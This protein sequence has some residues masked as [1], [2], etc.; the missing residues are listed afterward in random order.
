MRRV[1]SEAHTPALHLET[2]RPPQGAVTLNVVCSYWL[3]RAHYDAVILVKYTGQT[4]SLCHNFCERPP[5]QPNCGIGVTG[6]KETLQQQ[7]WWWWD[8][9]RKSLEEVTGG[10]LWCGYKPGLSL[11]GSNSNIQLSTQFQ[12][13]ATQASDLV[14]FVG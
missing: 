3:Q 8:I 5:A 10:S 1:V 2:F 6:S 11:V 9:V 4:A 13:R 14:R 7:R 12:R